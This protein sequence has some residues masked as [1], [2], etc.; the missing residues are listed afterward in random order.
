MKKFLDEFRKFI[1]K[2][3]VLDLAV[4]VIIGAAFQAIV[5]SLTDDVL[6]PIIGLVAKTDFSDWVLTINGVDI[7]YGSFITAVIQFLIM[8]MVVFLI[9]KGINKVKDLAVKKE[10]EAPKTKK[11]PYCFTDI[12]I[13][14]TR[15][16]NCTSVI[17]AEKAKAE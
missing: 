4:G 17:E 6:S 2:G 13:K 3:N 11:C 5:K 10:P 1:A 15:C 16:P 14:A 7:K 8:A 9:V 12:D